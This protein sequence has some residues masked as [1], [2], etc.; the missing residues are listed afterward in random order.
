VKVLVVDDEVKIAELVAAELRDAGFETA[1]VR[2]G[3]EALERLGTERFD[4]VVTDLRMA[5]PDGLA[6]LKAV[7]ER[8]PDTAVVLMTAYAALETARAALK[9][10]AWDYVEKEGEFA[11]VIALAL[12]QAGERTRLQSDVKH[13]SAAVES[14]RRDALPVVGDA[15]ATKRA[16]ELARKV[17]ATDST[18]LLR[19]ESGTGKDL[20]ARTIHALSRRAGGPYVKVNCGALPEALLESE[21][22]GHEKGAF[23]GAIRQKPG[24]FEDAAGGT[25]LLDEIGEL[26][27]ALQVK[28]L[29][30]IEEKTFTRVGG[31]ASITVDVRILAATNRPLEDMVKER[32]FREDL[33]YRLNVFPIVLPPLRERPGDVARLAAHVLRREG[34]APEKLTPAAVRALEGYAFPGNVRELENTL[35]RAMILAGS[36]PIEPAHL[37][38]ARP[39]LRAA[40]SWVPEIPEEGLSLEVLERE[41]ILK[42]LER[43]AGNKSQAARLLGLTR[44]TLYSRMEKHGLHKPGEGDAEAGDEGEE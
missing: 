2:G 25:L 26:P 39:E 3:S 14:I 23:T 12:R 37:S 13:L 31:N 34:A 1:F 35:E 29:Q 30:V 22:F 19:G 4:A 41:L 9:A 7:R 5:P 8:W 20:F 42:A 27:V 6:V 21:L 24:R 40:T 44:R 17:A 16:L 18:V 10:G 38:F 32:T 36:D 15:P 43:A 11:E 28:L 33:F